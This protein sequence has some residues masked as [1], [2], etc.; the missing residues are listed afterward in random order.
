MGSAD[1]GLK[2]VDVRAGQVMRNL[3]TKRFG[4]TEWV[5]S[6]SHCPDGRII[7]GGMDSKL[8]LWSATGVSCVDLVGHLGSISR[9]RTHADQP[10]AVSAGYDRVLRAWDLRSKTEVACCT[11]HDAPVLDFI[12][13]ND[14]IASGDRAGTVRIWDACRAKHIACLHGHKGHI[15]AMLALPLDGRAPPRGG[16]THTESEPP[17]DDGG[18]SGR[19]EA[20]PALIA[21]GAQDG[22][23]RIWDLRQRLNTF[24]L[25]AHPG[26]AV[27]DLGLTLGTSPPVLLSVG[28]DGRLLAL[29][30]RMSFCTL[31]DYGRITED[32]VYSLLVLDDIAFTGDGRGRVT[33]F[34]LRTGLLKYTLDAGQNAIRCMCATDASLICAGDDG[35]AIIFDF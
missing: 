28:A 32:F 23:I 13:A 18:G 22:Q 14:V 30:P 4:H 15:T 24:T 9:V 2:E 7:S 3:Y 27:N 33:C 17:G 11:G 31:F 26:G 10:L 25:G 19:T 8:C 5:T 29:D 16:A 34:D 1:H 20:D 6:V 12:W 21:T 35:N